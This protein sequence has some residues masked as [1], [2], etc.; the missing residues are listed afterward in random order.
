M[1]TIKPRERKHAGSAALRHPAAAPF[2]EYLDA[3]ASWQLGSSSAPLP[4]ASSFGNF[5][6]LLWQLSG[7][8]SSW[9]RLLLFQILLLHQFVADTDADGAGARTA[10][11][12]KGCGIWDQGPS[13]GAFFLMPVQVLHFRRWRV[14]FYG[15]VTSQSAAKAVSN[16]L[17]MYDGRSRE[18]CAYGIWNSNFYLPPFIYGSINKEYKLRLLLFLN[19]QCTGVSVAAACC[20]ENQPSR[21][22]QSAVV[23]ADVGV[24]VRSFI[25][26]SSSSLRCPAIGIRSGVGIGI[27]VGILP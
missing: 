18:F 17:I 9:L 7:I 8:V 15:L 4:F 2:A 12:S 10:S 16:L 19:C 23:V 5:H 20:A 25:C 6:L 27:G 24:R 11:S 21:K 3:V 26:A 1:Y 13:P 14:T 22:G